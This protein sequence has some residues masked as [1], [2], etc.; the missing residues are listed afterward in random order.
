MKLKRNYK[1]YLTEVLS[2]ISTGEFAIHLNDTTDSD[3][4]YILLETGKP[5][6]ETI[7]YHRKVGN[8]FYAYGINRSAP[9]EHEINAQVLFSN[10]ID[11]LNYA[12][13]QIGSQMFIYKKSTQDLIVTGG[14]FYIDGVNVEIADLDTSAEF[15]N[16]SIINGATNYIYIANND[17][18]ITD[19]P[20]AKEAY[21]VATFVVSV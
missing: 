16:K 8:T 6:E 20:I 9:V 3:Q 4:G 15:P 5:K 2:N 14:T 18:L 21:L 7:F 17:Y 10:S 19:T 13:D 12:L 11:Y 1:T